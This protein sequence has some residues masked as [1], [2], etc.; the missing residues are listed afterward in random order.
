MLLTGD[1]VV[2][3]TIN[4]P[5]ALITPDAVFEDAAMLPI[6]P[7]AAVLNGV[8]VRIPEAPTV[9]DVA[10]AMVPQIVT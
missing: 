5:V 6:P 9:T 8:S 2:T 4:G 1:I 7:K 10:P 3:A